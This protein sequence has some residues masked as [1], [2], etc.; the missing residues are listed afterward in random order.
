MDAL[1]ARLFGRFDVRYRQQILSGFDAH[2]VQDL[3]CCLWC[4][5]SV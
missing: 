4:I 1:R 5:C 3:F 2:K